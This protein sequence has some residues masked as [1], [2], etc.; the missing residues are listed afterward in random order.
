LTGKQAA[1]LRKKVANEAALLLYLGQEKEYKQAKLR[2]AETLG[3][4]A[5]PSNAEVAEALDTIAEDREGEGRKKRLVLM[6]EEAHRI[7]KLLQ[8]MCPVLT[9]SVWRGTAHKNSDI[10]IVAFSDKPNVILQKLEKNNYRITKTEYQSITKHGEEIRT[11]HI[12]LT[13]SSGIEAEII[14]RGTERMHKKEKCEIYGDV[15]TG[16]NIKQ[17]QQLLKT[18]PTQ[19]FIPT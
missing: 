15:Q 1:N 14:V 4:R 16:L 10:D 7:M 8:D 18:A 2:A 13:L 9:G 3:A 6:R 12:H 19:K 5:L 11:F 17:L